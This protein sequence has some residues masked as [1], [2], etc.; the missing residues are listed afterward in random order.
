MSAPRTLILM[1]VCGCGKTL[2][3]SMLV[4]RP[5]SAQATTPTPL[6][7]GS[8]NAATAAGQANVQAAQGVAA[9]A[10]AAA[11][12]AATTATTVMIART[13]YHC[14][15]KVARSTCQPKMFSRATSM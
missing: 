2:I 1:G 5:E 13:R 9:D 6:A 3:G 4:A 8:V 12:T 10:A 11:S 7:T 14:C 15:S